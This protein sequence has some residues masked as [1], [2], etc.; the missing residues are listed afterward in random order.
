MYFFLEYNYF[1]VVKPALI[2]L[3]VWNNFIY[4]FIYK[5][6]LKLSNAV[7]HYFEHYLLVMKLQVHNMSSIAGKKQPSTVASA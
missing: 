7:V 4:N 3:N 6:N 2:F 5:S 1:L